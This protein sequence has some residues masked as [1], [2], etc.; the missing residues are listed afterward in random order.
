[1]GA[2]AWGRRESRGVMR[3]ADADAASLR[4]G[5]VVAPDGP[6]RRRGGQRLA[7]TGISDFR[8]TRR[9]RCGTQHWRL[10]ASRARREKNYVRA[11]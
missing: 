4:A 11:G 6:S 8:D 7:I 10:E 9:A 1:M 2:T 3:P 5:L